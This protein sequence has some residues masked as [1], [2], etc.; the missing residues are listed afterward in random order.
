MTGES[1]CRRLRSLLLYLCYLFSA[2]INSLV[3][4][5]LYEPLFQIFKLSSVEDIA[6]DIS[7]VTL[8]LVM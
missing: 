1:Y 8:L 7:E 4:L 5:S 2:L 3:L 6:C